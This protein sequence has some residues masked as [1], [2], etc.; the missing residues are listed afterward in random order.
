MPNFSVSNLDPKKP[1]HLKAWLWISSRTRDR[2]K[3]LRAYTQ[4]EPSE[5]L[6]LLALMGFAVM[7]TRFLK[8]WIPSITFANVGKGNIVIQMK[9]LWKGTGRKKWT[10][11]VVLTSEEKLLYHWD[12][13][14]SVEASHARDSCDKVF[15]QI[16]ISLQT[17]SELWGL[18]FSHLEGRVV[19]LHKLWS[20]TTRKLEREIRIFPTDF[21]K[22]FRLTLRYW[23]L[24]EKT[25]RG[26]QTDDS[27]PENVN[28]HF[29]SHK[30]Y[31]Y[32]TTFKLLLGSR[33]WRRPKLSLCLV[34]SKEM[35]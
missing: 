2:K 15:C 31:S 11:Y 28:I 4:P 18:T 20:K 6:T 7:I 21:Q 33:I 22:K 8:L 10:K 24:H 32:L 29:W 12:V 27:T 35:L 17:S 14:V 13:G 16:N 5:R 3:T 34:H 25:R 1:D 23:H 26:K 19:W 9:T 30:R